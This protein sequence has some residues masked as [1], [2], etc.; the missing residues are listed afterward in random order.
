MDEN[1]TKRKSDVPTCVSVDGGLEIRLICGCAKLKLI[2]ENR[3]VTVISADY[4]NIG[5][6]NYDLII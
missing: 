1:N 4:N 6:M 5:Y 2:T 3:I